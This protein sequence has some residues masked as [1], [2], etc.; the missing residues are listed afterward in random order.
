MSVVTSCSLHAPRRGHAAEEGAT[1]RSRP[2][3][4]PGRDAE[5]EVFG[6]PGSSDGC[7]MPTGTI[8]RLKM[9][10]V[11]QC[12]PGDTGTEHWDGHLEGSIQPCPGCR[13]STAGSLLSCG[14]AAER[15]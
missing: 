14:I 13:S 9:G 12:S 4:P 10:M 2:E 5:E 8:R 1:G 7:R 11:I 3:G 6:M 15:V